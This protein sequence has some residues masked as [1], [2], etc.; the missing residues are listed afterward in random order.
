VVFDVHGG[1]EQDKKPRPSGRRSRLR[2]R[3][4]RLGG[5]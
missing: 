1:R 4:R 2:E 3:L 5:G